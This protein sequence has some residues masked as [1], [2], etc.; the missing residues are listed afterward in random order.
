M[1]VKGHTLPPAFSEMI[2]ASKRPVLVDFW[3]DWCGP[4]RTVT[5]VLARIAQE[6]RGRL[7][8]IKVNVDEKQD[9]AAQ[10][11]VQS[12]PTLILFWQG[13]PVMTVVGARSFEE[14]KE[15]IEMHWP[16]D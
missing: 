14:L 13:K 12:I 2:T 16:G 8:T 5:P 9:V 4:C 7:L 1:T 10:Y 15:Q 11:Q 6:Y 3:A